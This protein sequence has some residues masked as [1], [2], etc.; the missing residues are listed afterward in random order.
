M[1]H[2]SN[3]ACI[4]ITGWPMAKTIATAPAS[5]MANRRNVIIL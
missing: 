2:I 5:R 1:S 3:T 4:Q